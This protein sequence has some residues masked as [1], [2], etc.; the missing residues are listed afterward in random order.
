MQHTCLDYNIKWHPGDLNV[1][2]SELRLIPPLWTEAIA[3]PPPPF[4][5]KTEDLSFNHEG[6]MGGAC[7]TLAS[8]APIIQMRIRDAMMDAIMEASWAPIIQM[9]IRDAM[10]DAFMDGSHY[11][12]GVADLKVWDLKGVT[13]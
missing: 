13:G 9:R 10:M 1:L 11:L 12:K 5:L 2:W 7:K 6:G 8:W 3:D 4:R